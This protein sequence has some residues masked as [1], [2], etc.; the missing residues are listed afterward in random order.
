LNPNIVKLSS[1]KGL[2]FHRTL[3][4][5]LEFLF[6]GFEEFSGS[7]I[8][9]FFDIAMVEGL[10]NLRDA[11]DDLDELVVCLPLILEDGE[12]DRS[13]GGVDVGVEDALHAFDD[14]SLVGVVVGDGVDEG[15]LT[16]HV[17]A[18]DGLDDNVHGVDGVG[19]GELKH[20]MEEFFILLFALVK[21]SDIIL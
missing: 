15:E 5:G 7:A 13:V 8:E 11:V 10:D 2:P 20:N 18:D 17:V 21:I 9:G 1:L 14:G 19:F 3:N 6:I 12:A 16:V 4:N